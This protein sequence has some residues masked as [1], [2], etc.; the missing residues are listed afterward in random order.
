MNDCMTK[1]V[2]EIREEKL[3]EEITALVRA[4]FVDE[5]ISKKQKRHTR[6]TK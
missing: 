6:I 4:H 3:A 2:K 1:Y 5:V